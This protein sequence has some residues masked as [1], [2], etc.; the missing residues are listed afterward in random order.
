MRTP[1]SVVISRCIDQSLRHH[2]C[3]R[4]YI[5]EGVV[6]PFAWTLA[7][8]QRRCFFS[9]YRAV[10]QEV[11]SLL[12]VVVKYRNFIC[13]SHGSTIVYYRWWLPI[14]LGLKKNSIAIKTSF[15]FNRRI[16]RSIPFYAARNMYLMEGLSRWIMQRAMGKLD[17]LKNWKMNNW[18]PITDG[19]S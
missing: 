16:K 4:C 9:I 11:S 13:C 1:S 3:R 14:S 6:T 2:R 5:L 18:I 7:R 12:K 19:E 8:E 17:H 15:Y 10:E